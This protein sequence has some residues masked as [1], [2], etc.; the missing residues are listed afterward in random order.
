MQQEFGKL[1]Y[2]DPRIIWPNEA[3]DFTPWLANQIIRL[4]E[5]LGMELELEQQEAEVGDFSVDILAKDLGTRQPVIIENQLTNT[6]HDHL[7]KLLTY[8]GGIA[9]Q[10]VIWVALS[11]RE[12]HRQAL[13]WLNQVTGTNV[14]FFGVVIEIFKIDDSKPAYRFRPVVFPNEWQKTRK[15]R[16]EHDISSRARA[17]KSFFQALIDELREKHHFTGARA[18]QPQNWY[19]FSSGIGGISYCT[20]FTQ[21]KRVRAEVNIDLGDRKSVV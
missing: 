5:S 14:N 2:V 3:I 7:G 6:D 1:S 8:A 18:G 12:E 15:A 19:C 13:E 16:T 11:I 17:Y 10:T 20:S 9:A 4:G 21:G